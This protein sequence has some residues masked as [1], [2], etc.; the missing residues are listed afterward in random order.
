MASAELSGLQSVA[1]TGQLP[2]GVAWEEWAKLA[3]GRIR[4]VLE[5]FLANG[6][7]E[8]DVEISSAHVEELCRCLQSFRGCGRRTP[9]PAPALAPAPRF[10]RGAPVGCLCLPCSVPFVWVRFSV[11]F[12][13][14]CAVFASF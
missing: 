5:E 11:F 4:Q 9:P 8:G 14:W 6:V 1:T 13:V 3:E 2:E 10:I 12:L 7:A